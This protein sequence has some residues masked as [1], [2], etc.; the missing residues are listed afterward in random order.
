MQ[1]AMSPSVLDEQGGELYV[2]KLSVDADFVVEHGIVSYVTSIDAAKKLE[3]IGSNPLIVRGL[4]TSGA[5]KADVVVANKDA[6]AILGADQK[7]KVLD[8]ARVAFLL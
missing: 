7:S 6:Q 1:P 8:K 3:R 4:K 5:F 2:G